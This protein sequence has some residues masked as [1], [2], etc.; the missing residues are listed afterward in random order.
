MLTQEKGCAVTWRIGQTKL[1]EVSHKPLNQKNPDI[2][3]R[4]W[5]EAIS[6]IEIY[7][8]NQ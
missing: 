7:C 1:P 5:D 3:D 6:K 8:E 4:G 2:A